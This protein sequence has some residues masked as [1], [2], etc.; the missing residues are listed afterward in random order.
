M[1]GAG[2][3]SHVAGHF[4]FWFRLSAMIGAGAPRE[5][6]HEADSSLKDGLL[7][8]ATCFGIEAGGTI[9]G[10]SPTTSSFKAFARIQ[11]KLLFCA[12]KAAWTALLIH[13][14]LL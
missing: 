9:S 13:P 10:S 11:R 1:P 3:P 4:E 6:A 7:A 8:G 2:L 5:V 12:R 14:R